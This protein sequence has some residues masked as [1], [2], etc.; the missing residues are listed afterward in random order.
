MNSLQER[1]GGV[2]YLAMIDPLIRLLAVRHSQ[3]GIAEILNSKGL[4]RSSGLMWNQVAVSRYFKVEG[5][6]SAGQFH[7]TKTQLDQSTSQ[8]QANEISQQQT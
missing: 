5:I 2:R 8:G 4:F 1:L 6:T 3:K 7:K